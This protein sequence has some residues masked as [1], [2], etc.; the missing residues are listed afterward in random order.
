MK[1]KNI[2]FIYAHMDDEAILSYGTL[3]KLTKNNNILLVTLCGNGRENDYKKSRVKQYCQILRK[4][5]INHTSLIENDLSLDKNKIFNYLN[6]CILGFKPNIVFTHSQND[7]HFEHRL[8]A[9]QVLLNCR[10]IPNSTIK[11]LY[12]TVSPTYNWTYG[13]Y[14]SFQ[15]NTFIDISEYVKEKE[16]ALKLYNMELPENQL[17]NRSIDSIMTW[18]K[19]YGHTIGVKYVEPYEQVFSIL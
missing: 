5:N 16:E 12:T 15:P 9:E 13:Q 1:N 10:N 17:D 19:M 7:L 4:L 8:V 6:N 18:N 3:A 11:T 2:L 14:G